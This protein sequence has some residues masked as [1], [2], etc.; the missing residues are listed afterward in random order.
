[1]AF[2]VYPP[3]IICCSAPY[4]R[5]VDYFWMAYISKLF[6]AINYKTSI[7]NY[8]LGV[9]L[10]YFRALASQHWPTE[11]SWTVIGE[12]GQQKLDENRFMECRFCIVAF[13]ECYTLTMS[14]PIA[15]KRSSIFS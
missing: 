12:F 8:N 2:E 10:P 13:A 14:A 1:M 4:V 15:R 7:D 9:D 5:S 6:P 3:G 11:K